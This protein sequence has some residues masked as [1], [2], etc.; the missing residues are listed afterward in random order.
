MA[1]LGRI[2]REH[3]REAGRKV[4]SGRTN[5]TTATGKEGTAKNHTAGSLSGDAKVT[6]ERNDYSEDRSPI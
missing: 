2:T 1:G 4:D 5:G 3:N 6:E